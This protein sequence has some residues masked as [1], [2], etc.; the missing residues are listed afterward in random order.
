MRVSELAEQYTTL[1]IEQMG[2][3]I[4]SPTTR[5]AD[6]LEPALPSRTQAQRFVSIR[7]SGPVKEISC[8]EAESPATIDRAIGR[9]LPSWQLIDSSSPCCSNKS[10]LEGASNSPRATVVAQIAGHDADGAQ[11]NCSSSMIFCNR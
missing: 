3:S 9:G 1:P 10:L 8:L 11:G 5:N 2:A 4:D 6:L 7:L